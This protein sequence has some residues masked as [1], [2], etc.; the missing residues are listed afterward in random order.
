[1]KGDTRHLSE[2]EGV[3]GR[4]DSIIL[5]NGATSDQ[6][7]DSKDAP[8]PPILEAI[9][10]PEIRGGRARQESGW[11]QVL[12]LWVGAQTDH[13]WEGRLRSCSAQP[14][15]SLPQPL[16]FLTPAGT[17]R[18]GTLSMPRIM[19]WACLH[20]LGSGPSAV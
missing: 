20:R 2:E 12:L 7:S 4:E 9:R 15:P 19:G 8:S 13:S 18:G 3:S 6:S 5:I 14:L 17:L 11:G 10:T 16:P 1:M